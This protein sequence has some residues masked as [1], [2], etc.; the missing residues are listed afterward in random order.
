[1]APLIDSSSSTSENLI[2]ENWQQCQSQDPTI[3][4]VENIKTF[5]ISG[6]HLFV[7]PDSAADGAA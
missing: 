5:P 6:G 4:P 2:Y 3:W 1:M 7:L